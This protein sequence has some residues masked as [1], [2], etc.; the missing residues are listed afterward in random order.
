MSDVTDAELVSRVLS[1]DQDAYRELVSR[2][3]GHVYG[4]AYSIV[5]HWADA[6]DIAQEVFIRAY[7][8]LDQ[9]RD[10]TRFAAWLRR[11]T[12]GVTMNWLKAFR[13]G[14]F[15][16]LGH[17]SGPDGLDVP[18]FRPGPP[19]IAEKKD[20]ADAVL[21]AVHSLPPRYRIPLTMFH[22]GWLSYRKVAEFLDVPLGTGPPRS[23]SSPSPTPPW[24][25]FAGTEH[26]TAARTDK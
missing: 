8:N 12:F 9:L 13:P 24:A 25:D 19:E 10:H 18:D 16:H 1:G 21:G 22:L 11:V 5:D 15:R 14:L 17:L 26:R 23:P 6:Q 20:L 4:L 3:Q 2:Y 7:S